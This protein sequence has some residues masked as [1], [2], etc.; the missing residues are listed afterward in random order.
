MSR[1]RVFAEEYAMPMDKAN[2]RVHKFLFIFHE[3]EM[4]VMQLAS[5]WQT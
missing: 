1:E 2:N 5:M 4:I 3:K